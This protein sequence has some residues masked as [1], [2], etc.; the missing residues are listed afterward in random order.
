MDDACRILAGWKNL[1]GNKDPRTTE[2]N[3]GLAKRTT[4]SE[5]KKGNKKKEVTCYKCGKAGHYSNECDE[6]ETV[7]TSNKKGSNF[8]V[9]NN[10]TDHNSL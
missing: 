2:A 9:L 5:D 4:I 6:V 10:D 7:K 3:D 8:L 1:Y